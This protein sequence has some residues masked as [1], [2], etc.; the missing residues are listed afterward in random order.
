MNN[1]IIS[2]EDTLKGLL[3]E[4]HYFQSLL[5]V[6]YANELLNKPELEKIQIQVLE[7]LNENISYYT[8]HESSSVRVEIAEQ[9]MLS[10]Y[11]TIGI[12]MKSIPSIKESI[13]LLKEKS[14]KDMFKQGEVMI[15]AKVENCKRL[16]QQVQTNKLATT[17][18]S[19]ID[20]I[21]YGFSMF[22]ID[23]D[24]RFASHEAP[25]S[26]DYQLSDADIKL[27]GVEY[28]EAYLNTI[29]L[30][31]SFCANF[32]IF[33]I[34]TLLKSFNRNSEHM[35][36]NIFDFVLTNYLGVI[37]MEKRGDTLNI[38]KEERAYLKSKLKDLSDVELKKIFIMA[39]EKLFKVLSIEDKELMDYI[40]KTILK[41]L[42]QI[43]YSIDTNTLENTF[44]T[45]NNSEENI[46]KYQDGK[47][48]DDSKFK[49]ITEEIRACSKVEDK[50][51]II[52]EELHSLQDLVDVLG[53]DCIFDEEFSC[54][55]KGLE[56]F[57]LSLLLKYLPNNESMDSD[58]GTESEKE[59][60]EKL[61]E[62]LGT[63]DEL[64]KDEI[65]RISEGIEI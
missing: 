19:Y 21:D 41:L 60:Q 30:E 54:I 9:L 46:L 31:N 28:I 48:L 22:F 65:M 32:N 47:I 10:I 27:V 15:R 25:C 57:E 39:S 36:I 12:Y 62:Y 40:N 55:F 50:M 63:I 34:E 37:L 29:R 26:I 52:R 3:S 14:L 33:E 16:F 64:K 59:W 61:K 53:A 49:N 20:T 1:S 5:Q 8:K 44:I 17:N 45:L 6:L 43:K 7:V 13:A 11:Y 56:D 2:R 24:I 42:P 51:K 58:Y 35:L 38:T 4:E 23:Y 18:Y